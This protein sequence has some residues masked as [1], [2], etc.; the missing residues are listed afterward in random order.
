MAIAGHTYIPRTP[1]EVDEERAERIAI[2]IY[3]RGMT[4]ADSIRAADE[5]LGL[6]PIPDLFGET[7]TEQPRKAARSKR[8]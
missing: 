5:L 6:A 7:R 8:R 1:S 4:E 2:G 3:E